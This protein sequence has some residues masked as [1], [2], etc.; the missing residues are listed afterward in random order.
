MKSLFLVGRMQPSL[1]LLRAIEPLLQS[2]D[3]LRECRELTLIRLAQRVHCRL[4][5]LA[6]LDRA[7]LHAQRVVLRRECTHL[8]LHGVGID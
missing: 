1:L 3:L 2:I 5:A 7:H 8:E 4:D 6:L